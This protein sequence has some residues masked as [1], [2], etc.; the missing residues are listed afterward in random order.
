M[1]TTWN[2]SDKN[3]ATLSNGNLTATV[4]AV[5]APAYARGTFALSTGKAYFEITIAL[6]DIGQV[7]AGL[8]TATAAVDSGWSNQSGVW[9][10]R[11]SGAIWEDDQSSTF[12]SSYGDAAVVGVAVDFSAGKVW[13]SVDGVFDSGDPAAGTGPHATFTSGSSLFPLWGGFF[14]EGSP[15]ISGT[16]AFTA[17]GLTHAAPSGFSAWDDAGGLETGTAEASIEV[18]VSSLSGSAAAPISL[19]VANTGDGACPITVYVTAEEFGEVPGT[20]TDARGYVW[21]ARVYLDDVNVS[22]RLVDSLRVHAEEDAAR[23]ADFTLVASPGPINPLAW[24]STPVRIDFVRVV[25]QQ[26][27]L[28]P[29]EQPYRLFTGKVDLAH[30]DPVTRKVKFDCTDD[31]QNIVA[32]LSKEDIDD[33]VGGAFSRG[34]QGEVDEHWEYAQARLDTVFGSLDCNAYAG[35]RVTLWD[36]LPV[37]RIFTDDMVVDGS[38]EVELPRRKDLV[39]QIAIAHQYRFHRLRE[40]RAS[41]AFSASIIGTQA[42]ARG[43]QLPRQAEIESSLSSLGWHVISTSFSQGFDYVAIGDPPGCPTGGSGDWWMVTGGGCSNASL[44]LGQ[45][46]A[47]PITEEYAITVTA[48][49]SV[50]AHGVIEKPLRGALA[51][52]WNPEAW[53]SDLSLAPDVLAADL[54]YA[55]DAPRADCDAAITALVMMAQRTILAS[56]RTARV[57]WTTPLRPGVDVSNAAHIDTATV[58]ASGKIADFTHTLD[59]AT[60]AATTR[61]GIAI[62]GVAAGG[63]TASDPVTVPPPPDVDAEIGVDDWAAGLPDLGCHVGGT[64]GSTYS[65]NL[66]GFLINAPAKLTAYNFTLG[67]SFSWDNPY[68]SGEILNGAIIS[69]NDFPVEGFRSRFPGVASSH[70]QAVGLAKEDEFSV[71]IPEDTFIL[72]A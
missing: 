10:L 28:A 12:T 25:W 49:G 6:T 4:A 14:D 34:A 1:A 54:D 16:A 18:T 68:W 52:E 71:G 17:A 56:H 22:A 65:D 24:T 7:W 55:P 13:F 37:W 11:G 45:R 64:T 8:A 23:V 41:V 30:Y 36:D 57:R 50:A 20:L 32:A 44:R 72:S 27:P 21:K 66:M 9:A 5:S 15:T 53:E 33:L 48:P 35:P 51:S 58:E 62:S 46:H 40:R 39:N 60:G 67:Q 70:R 47:Q 43:Y 69:N 2:P 19:A 3:G 26:P 29:L 31:V 61:I 38:I 59:I 42:Y 63:I